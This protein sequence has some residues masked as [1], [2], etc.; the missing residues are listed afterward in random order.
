MI[1]LL[2]EY[3][4]IKGYFELTK[5]LNLYKFTYIYM[6]TLWLLHLIYYN[7]H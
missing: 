5:E 2:N 4:M 1:I 6:F 3:I 7:I